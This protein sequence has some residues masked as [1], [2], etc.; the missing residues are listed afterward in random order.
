[1]RISAPS[2]VMLAL[3]ALCAR[4]NTPAPTDAAA[5]GEEVLEEIVVTAREPLYVAP[6]T[7]DRIG[8]VWVPVHIDGRGPFRLVLDTGAQRSAIT[9]SVAS[10]LQLPLD[11]SPPV[12]LHGVTGTA[13]TPTVEVEHLQVGDVWMR[14]ERL[15]VVAD[16]FGGAEGLL[17]VD[18]LQQRRIYINFGADYVEISR[19]RNLRAA[20]GFFVLPFQAG[21]HRLVA[22][23]AE[24][25]GVRVLAV[26]DTGAQATVANEALRVALRRE[27]SRNRRGE[28]QIRGATGDVLEGMGAE[29]S[30]I[31]MGS[32][33]VRGAHVTFSELPIFAKWDL[34]D[35]P[36]LLVGMD[37]LGLLDTLVIDY[38]REEV[39]IKPRVG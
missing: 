34:A 28:D 29:V 33:Q 30:Q 37:I 24:V 31:T 16:V 15:P 23:D 10:R 27:V 25:S 20:R 6:T 35:R 9:P 36:A 39:H 21:A 18:G 7:R 4:A 11:R 38:L 17:G 13:V 14:S 3:L 22:V 12:R 2:A 8:R 19:S 26:L 32:L 1:V 5:S